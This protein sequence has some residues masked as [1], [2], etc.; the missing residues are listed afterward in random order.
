M[1][2]S[3]VSCAKIMKRSYWH[4]K[5][6]PFR[7]R[8]FFTLAGWAHTR[9][10]PQTVEKSKSTTVHLTA[11]G[12]GTWVSEPREWVFNYLWHSSIRKRGVSIIC[13][14]VLFII[15]KDYGENWRCFKID[16]PFCLSEE[17]QCHLENDRKWVLNFMGT[18]GEVTGGGGLRWTYCEFTRLRQTVG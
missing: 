12:N 13:S 8:W 14:S 4:I 3:R 17:T 7:L 1:C 10:L 2:L 18:G 16:H 15:V 11:N 5:S 6:M 9:C